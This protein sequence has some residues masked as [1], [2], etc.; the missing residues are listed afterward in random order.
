LRIIDWGEERQFSRGEIEPQRK[1]VP[2]RPLQFANWMME[3][4]VARSNSHFVKHH[5]RI[6]DDRKIR[7]G[8]FVMLRRAL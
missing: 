8:I 7:L 2:Q 5:R 4:P 3:Q 1:R 6:A